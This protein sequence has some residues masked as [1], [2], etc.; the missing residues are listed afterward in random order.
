MD[1]LEDPVQLWF[2]GHVDTVYRSLDVLQPALRAA[3]AAMQDTLLGDKKL[4]AGGTGTGCALAQLFCAALL[5]RLSMERPALPVI[6]IGNDAATLGAIAEGYGH[7]EALARQ[8]QAL[9]APGDTVLLV[10]G[11]SGTSLAG[12]VRAAHGR[13]ARVILLTSMSGQEQAPLPGEGD[14]EIRIP[15]EEPTRATECQLL[16]LNCLAELL[17]QGIFGSG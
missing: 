17:E 8:V 6:L 2:T 10:A 3:A 7:T 13:R 15:A 16:V 11:A 5:S 14:I 4:I 1:D 12:A 9:T